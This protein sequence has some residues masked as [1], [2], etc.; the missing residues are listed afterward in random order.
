[1]TLGRQAKRRDLDA[2][3]ILAGMILMCLGVGWDVLVERGMVKSPRLVSYFFLV[4]ILSIA[5]VLANRFVRVHNESDR[6]N[7]ELAEKNASLQQ[8]DQ[9]KDEFLANTS[10]ELRTPLNGIIGIA[11]SLIDGAAARRYHRR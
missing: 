5:A 9:L 7:R 6:L 4:F 10:H 8:I 2:S 3:I 1:M 11:D